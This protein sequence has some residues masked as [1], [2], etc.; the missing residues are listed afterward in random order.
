[1]GQS[2]SLWEAG[3]DTWE[4]AV[5]KCCRAVVSREGEAVMDLAGVTYT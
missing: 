2:L 4:A 5:C 1:M 3:R